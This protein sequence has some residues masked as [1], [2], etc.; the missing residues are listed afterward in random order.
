MLFRRATKGRVGEREGG[1]LPCPFLKIEKSA[2]VL[3]KKGPN[4]SIF[5]LNFP[6]KM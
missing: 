6:F 3:E 2:L 5:G 4:L 1:D